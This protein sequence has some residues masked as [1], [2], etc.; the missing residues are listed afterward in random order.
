MPRKTEQQGLRL[1]A[2]V[3]NRSYIPL[4]NVHQPG[5]TWN[6]TLWCNVPEW[7]VEPS[8]DVT[9]AL[10]VQH[11]YLGDDSE[12]SLF[13]HNA[14]NKLSASVATKAAISCEPLFL[15]RQR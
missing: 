3:T 11:I 9:K 7:T 4:R 1:Q 14:L 12:V 5:L 13:A 10:A 8:L 15:L 2:T 6:A